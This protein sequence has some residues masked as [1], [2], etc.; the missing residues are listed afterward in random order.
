MG[1]PQD[2]PVYIGESA[3]AFQVP[4]ARWLGGLAGGVGGTPHPTVFDQH[5]VTL[6]SPSWLSSVGF[7]CQ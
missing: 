1:E 7:G 6:S 3:K 2:F 5:I 4:A